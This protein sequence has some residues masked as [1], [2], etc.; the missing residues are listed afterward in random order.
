MSGITPLSK[1]AIQASL[2]SLKG[3]YALEIC[4]TPADRLA[5]KSIRKACGDCRLSRGDPARYLGPGAGVR[6]I[7]GDRTADRELFAGVPLCVGRTGPNRCRDD[8]RYR[9]DLQRQA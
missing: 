7:A 3:Q 4:Q 6:G 2:E 8:G 9:A 1:A 5:R